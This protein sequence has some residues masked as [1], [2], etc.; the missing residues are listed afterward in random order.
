MTDDKTIIAT[1]LALSFLKKKYTDKQYQILKQNLYKLLVSSKNSLNKIMYDKTPL[2]KKGATS[3]NS[4]N[5][6]LFSAYSIQQSE[7]T[8]LIDKD[9]GDNKT[10]LAV[11]KGGD[12]ITKTDKVVYDITNLEN[13]LK[14]LTN[15]EKQELNKQVAKF[16]DF[17]DLQEKLSLI[18]QY[19]HHQK[20]RGVYY[21]PLVLTKYMAIS[22]FKLWKKKLQASNINKTDL[23]DIA[24]TRLSYDV[25]VL[26]PTCGLA[27]FLLTFLA[28]KFD[29]IEICQGEISGEDINKVVK[30][31][32]GNDISKESTTIAKL[33]VYLYIVERYGIEKTQE[34][35]NILDHNF[36]TT[37]FV[38][39]IK[40]QGKYDII[41]GNP[42]YVV[43]KKSG[44]VLKKKYGNI[45]ANVL[46]NA[47]KL[48]TEHG[49]MSFVIPMAYQFSPKMYAIRQVMNKEFKTHY[50]LSFS[51]RPCSFFT[52]VH[53]KLSV[54]FWGKDTNIDSRSS[55][56]N[57]STNIVVNHSNHDTVSNLLST[58][59]NISTISTEHQYPNKKIENISLFDN[60]DIAMTTNE[61]DNNVDT[62]VPRQ[63]FTRSHIFFYQEERD[64]VFD[65]ISVV[66]N[67]YETHDYIPKLGNAMDMSIYKKVTTGNT[68]IY[69]CLNK[70]TDNKLYLCMRGNLW[71]KVFDTAKSS[72]YKCFFCSD[73]D[74]NFLYCLLNS[75]LFWWYWIGISDCWHITKK[76]LNTMA[77]I[78]DPALDKQLSALANLLKQQMEN[79]AKVVIN[80]K[81]SMYAYKTKRC[82]DLIHEIDSLIN[83][84]YGLSSNESDYIKNFRLKY[85]MGRSR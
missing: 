46:D 8:S 54:C 22:I 59:T 39:D 79:K 76:E 19:S 72:E 74:Y 58:P 75:S 5:I 21:T 11:K 56:S 28:I 16:K 32:Y 36:T 35:I 27:E 31:I 20:I 70:H 53:E 48:L 15:E 50:I 40:I 64:H 13:E 24:D 49:V 47:T 12:D 25:K 83:K 37:D 85:R 51:A 84:S 3:L 66:E 33:R 65:N 7:R 23:T 18:N 44:L 61:I 55:N 62:L 52:G 6:D 77:A 67:N 4:D 26:D 2:A 10:T 45:F 69:D 30:T 41:V 71:I 82:V 17:K 9:R 80:T 14:A 29:I 81:Y 38:T 60:D 73:E 57:I 68:S 1:K 42:P 43:D 34:V 63:L 78:H